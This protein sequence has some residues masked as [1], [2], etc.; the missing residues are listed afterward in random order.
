M[1]SHIHSVKA[2]LSTY[3]LLSVLDFPLP[4]ILQTFPHP[5]VQLSCIVFNSCAVKSVGSRGIHLTGP[6]LIDTL[7]VSCLFFSPAVVDAT[8]MNCGLWGSHPYR[9]I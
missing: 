4:W 2:V 1:F 7:V 6:L 5:C 3:I 9:H 8:D